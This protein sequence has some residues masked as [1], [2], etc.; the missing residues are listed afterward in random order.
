MRDYIICHYWYSLNIK[1]KFQTE[2]CKVCHNL[3]QKAMNFNDAAIVTVKWNGY[4]IH[5]LYMSKD[6]AI[7]LLKNAALT[8]KS[9]ALQNIKIYYHA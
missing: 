9:R 2:I 7:N 8:E 1:F 5:F 4:W 3:L 6:V